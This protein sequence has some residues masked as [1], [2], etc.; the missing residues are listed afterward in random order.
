MGEELEARDRAH[1]MELVYG[2]LRWRF[3]LELLLAKLLSRPLRSK[4]RDIEL[5]LLL[6][7]YSLVELSTPDYAVVNEAV[8]Q[9]LRERQVHQIPG[10][11]E[12]GQ[13]SGMRTLERS[14]A[15]LV[16]DG[17]V[18]AEEALSV[19]TQ[20]KTLEQLLRRG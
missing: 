2:V 12:T 20:P 17:L 11:I 8:A 3:R 7:L 13:S 9:K 19:T 15:T 1:A 14:L 10:M 4:D 5:V 16:R 6:A 18:D